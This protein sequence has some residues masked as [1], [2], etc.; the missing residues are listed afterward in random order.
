MNIDN[1]TSAPVDYDV[2]IGP[3]AALEGGATEVMAVGQPRFRIK[4]GKT[5]AFQPASSG[6]LN[7]Y[8]LIDDGSQAKTVIE[9]IGAP[10][11]MNVKLESTVSGGKTFYRAQ[12]VPFS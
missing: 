6:A 4:P 3:F 7:H 12:L 10:D 9:L 2:D 11:S 8:F 5:F 1:D